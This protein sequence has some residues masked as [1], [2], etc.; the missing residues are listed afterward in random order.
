MDDLLN[1]YIEYEK[2]HINSNKQGNIYEKDSDD[3]NE[4]EKEDYDD[5]VERTNQYYKTMS[6]CDF[7]SAIWFTMSS[8]YICLSEYLKYKI[9]WKTRTNAV[10]D[11]SKR[12]ATKNMMYVK[13]FQA[14]AT[15]RNIVSTELNQFFS[16]YTDNVSYTS[17]EYDVDDLK[18]LEAKSLECSPH[19]SLRIMNNYTPIK[20]GLMS[21]IFKGYI[22]ETDDTPVVIKYLRKNISKNFNSSM[23]NLVMFAKITKYFPYLRTLNVENLILQNIVCLKD[24]VCFRKELSNITTYYNRWK[25]CEFVKIP[26]PY[27][28]YT[29]KINPD[30][31]VMEY[32]DGMKVT[33]IDPDD[34]DHFGKV[35]ATFN[36]NAAFSSAIYHGDLHPGNLLFIKEQRP[37]VDKEGEF[38]TIYKLGILDFGIIGR[39][40]RVDQEIFQNR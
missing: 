13:I 29:E 4:R 1:E 39:L 15:N 22:G 10:I 27:H 25:N 32:I 36:A 16:E 26:K 11:V 8:C 14:F 38:N 33:D 19:R 24:Q 17:E 34:Y 7:F 2:E 18:E 9:R 28:D 31:I 20:S 3:E 6:L 37:R 30:I 40:S 23:N 5:Y 21:L 12:L 35:L